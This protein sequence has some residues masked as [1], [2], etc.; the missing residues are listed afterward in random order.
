MMGAV[1]DLCDALSKLSGIPAE[2]VRVNY[3]DQFNL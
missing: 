3:G 2:N 1:S